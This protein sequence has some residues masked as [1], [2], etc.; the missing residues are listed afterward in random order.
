MEHSAYCST[1][2]TELAKAM[3]KVQA[4]LQPA[5]KDRNNPFTKSRYATLNSVMESCREALIAN[6][7]WF[8]Q[9]PVPV[10]PGFM[11]LVTK[12]THAESGQW[13]SSLLVMPL[14]KADP[15][16]FGSAMTYGR[17][18]SMAALIGIVTEED[19]D[20][21][22]AGAGTP[23]RTRGK[24]QTPATDTTIKNEA[25][26]TPPAEEPQVHPALASMPQLDGINY[27]LTQTQ[28]G[29]MCVI[30]A[31]NTRDKK[32]ILAQ[33]GFKWSE[34]RKIWWRYAEAA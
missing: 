11:G 16:G 7:I 14:P 19:D 25:A 12:L 9:Y 5:L 15:Q 10:E 26:F 17:R 20:G 18:Y 6:S 28:D 2:T 22:M 29:K 1:E 30:A 4:E 8:S 21:A 27:S 13:Q 3:L 33:A 31:G 32:Q 23:A 24:K 34:Q